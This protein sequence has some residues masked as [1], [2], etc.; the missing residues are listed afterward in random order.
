MN[1]P[2]VLTPP[3]SMRLHPGRRS[4][5]TR[6]A[7]ERAR[8]EVRQ[9]Q[10]KLLVVVGWITALVGVV[11]YCV[12]SFATGSD[13]GLAAILLDGAI[14]AARAGLF[15]IGGGTLLWVVGSVMHLN[16]SLDVSDGEPRD[17]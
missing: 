14:P 4:R 7:A 1:R 13:A 15:V 6:P 10:G 5:P 11:V 17:G 2:N 8:P 12:A 9:R 16:A 3:G